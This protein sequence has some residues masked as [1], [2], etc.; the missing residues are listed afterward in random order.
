MADTSRFES[1]VAQKRALE[2][3]RSGGVVVLPTDTLYGF[4]A[5]LSQESAIDRIRNLKGGGERRFVLLASSL[6]MVERYV[7]S[8]GCVAR[9]ELKERCLQETFSRRFQ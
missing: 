6:E 3:L 7:S 8:F 9:E 5:A 4:H 1:A 2:L